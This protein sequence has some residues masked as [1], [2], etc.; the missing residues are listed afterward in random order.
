MFEI[1]GWGALEV[2]IED[3]Q[4]TLEVS[5]K[6]YTKMADYGKIK[7]GLCIRTP[8]DGDYIVIDAKGSTKKL[9]RVFIDN[10]IDREK[11]SNW[12]ILANGNEVLWVIGLRYSESC[13]IQENTSKI[14]RLNYVGKGE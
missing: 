6:I 14:I 9:S 10:K 13:K 2:N 8:A 4:S 7:D 3:K 1:P 11:R 12:P 5:K